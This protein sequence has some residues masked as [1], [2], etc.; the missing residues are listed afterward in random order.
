MIRVTIIIPTFTPGATLERCLASIASQTFTDYEILIQDGG[1]TDN[2]AAIAAR[3]PAP[4]R[5]ISIPNSK[6]WRRAQLWDC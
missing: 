5:V 4:V 1:S 6:L 2:T 3:F